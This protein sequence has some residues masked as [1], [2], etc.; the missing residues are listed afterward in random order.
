[1]EFEKIAKSPQHYNDIIKSIKEKLMVCS[2]DYDY[3]ILSGQGT[4]ELNIEDK[5]YEL[6]DGSILEIDKVIKY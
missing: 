3:D 6:P 5:S 2:L 4:D 1:M